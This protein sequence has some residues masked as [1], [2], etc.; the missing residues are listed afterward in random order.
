[1]RC[2]MD[3]C[4][5]LRFKHANAKNVEVCTRLEDEQIRIIVEDDGIGIPKNRTSGVG[6][7]SMRERAEELGGTCIVAANMDRGTLVQ[8]SLPI[9]S[10]NG[11]N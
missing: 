9:R 3:C 5:S 1:M 7:N 11:A 2:N 10:S 4:K 6:L 8:V